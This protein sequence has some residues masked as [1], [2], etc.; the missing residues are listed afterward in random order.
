MQPSRVTVL[1]GGWIF[2]ALLLVVAG[3]RGI[4]ERRFPDADDA[5]RLLE[6]RD[7]LAGQGWFDVAQHRLNGGDFPMHWSRLVDLPLAAAIVV[8]RPWCGPPLAEHI[9][10]VVVPLLTLLVALSLIA[11]IARRLGGEALVLP[12]L[13]MAALSIPLT[14]QLSPLRIDHHGWQI[15][16]ALAVT[17]GLI[18]TPTMRSGS[19][20]GLA[21]ALL[22]TIS[23]E[24]LPIA[25]AIGAV[26]GLGWVLQP[27]RGAMLRA[28]LVTL[29]SGAVALHV[30]TR[31]P[32]FWLPACDAVAPAW[33]ATLAVATAGV[34]AASTI[35]RF[36]AAARSMALAG[37]GAA[38]GA[39]LVLLAPTCL[40]GPFGTLPPLVYRIWYLSVLEG[41]PLWEQ[42]S[43]W[44]VATL[45]LPLA[46]LLGAAIGWRHA[47]PEMRD[48]WAMIATL[49]LAATA[50]A[51]FVSRA[52]ATANALAAPAAAAWLRRVLVR[53]RRIERPMP[54]VVATVATLTLAAPGTLAAGLLQSVSN[55]RAAPE[56]PALYRTC[57]SAG[58]M[59][60]LAALPTGTV[61]APIDVTPALLVDTPHRAVA[62]G[63][64]RGA[65]AIARVITGFMASPDAARGV[66]VASRADYVA[67]CP[68]MQELD[69]YRQRAPNG[70]WARLARG[71]RIAWL[72]P[73]PIRGPAL[74]WQVIRPLPEGRSAP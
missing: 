43:V 58:D 26:A 49:L 71:E 30:A 3:W 52:G 32:D 64:H 6:V 21:L 12:A 2:A 67:V 4:V 55:E 22:L 34:V 15:V 68:G 9:A 10:L 61:F 19:I 50:T 73:L 18:A 48:R 13:L 8:L 27:G 72:L 37:A 31:G 24:G 35:E 33:L 63:Y 14:F 53:A 46:G 56:P 70:L 57:R 5:M 60:A 39:T 41:R 17:R 54:R 7:W 25:A 66:I 38:G 69:A 47:T 62:G 36:G 16:L 40:A 45:A 20:C 1:L 59:R 65:R 42:Q 11:A 44:A 28:M 74:A 51:V 29:T 23:L